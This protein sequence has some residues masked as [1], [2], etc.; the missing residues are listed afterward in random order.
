[1]LHPCG[2]AQ[3]VT[4]GHSRLLGLARPVARPVHGPVGLD[5]G[6]CVLLYTDGLL[7]RHERKGE[8]GLSLLVE[9]VSGFTG[10]PD[11]LCDRVTHALVDDSPRDDVCLLAGRVA[12]E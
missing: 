11:E 3:V 10:S 7:E 6:T 2:T 4:Q 5:P 1:M 9:T 8:D 12:G